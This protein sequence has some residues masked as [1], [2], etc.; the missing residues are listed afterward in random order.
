M[1]RCS[2]V[3]VPNLHVGLAGEDGSGEIGGGDGGGEHEEGLSCGSEGRVEEGA[4]LV[5]EGLC[6]LRGALVHLHALE[7]DLD[8]WT[9]T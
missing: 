8:G 4:N 1:Q 2:T 6:G 9:C 5:E 3:S 7:P